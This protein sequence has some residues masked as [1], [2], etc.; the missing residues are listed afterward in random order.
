M[1]TFPSD[2]VIDPTSYLTA[3]ESFQPGN[4]AM[5][6]VTLIFFRHLCLLYE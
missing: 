2:N 4:I 3:I 5:T 1:M 6:S